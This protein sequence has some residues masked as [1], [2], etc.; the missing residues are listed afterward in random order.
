LVTTDFWFLEYD[1]YEV[2]VCLVVRVWFG[3]TEIQSR[4]MSDGFAVNG[5]IQHSS[6]NPE[7][8]FASESGIHDWHVQQVLTFTLRKTQPNIYRLMR[9]GNA[10]EDSEAAHNSSSREPAC[11]SL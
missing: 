7:K 10:D 9:P 1:F 2:E 4:V 11:L 5:F 6:Q 3:Y 8:A